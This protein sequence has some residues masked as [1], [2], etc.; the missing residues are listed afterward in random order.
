MS[1]MFKK[2][3]GLAFKPK[4]PTSRSRTAAPTNQPSSQEPHGPVVHDRTQSPLRAIR[5]VTPASGGSPHR[6][7]SAQPTPGDREPDAHVEDRSHQSTTQIARHLIECETEETASTTIPSAG[8]AVVND[9]SEQNDPVISASSLVEARANDEA[10]LQQTRNDNQGPPPE[11]L[12]ALSINKELMLKGQPSNGVITTTVRNGLPS[13][14]LSQEPEIGLGKSPSASDAVNST[15]SAEVER[16]AITQNHVPSLVL[17]GKKTQKDDKPKKATRSNPKKR[18]I[19][20][21]DG[22]EEQLRQQ[23]RR[24]LT[25]DDSETRLVD[26]QKLKM[27]DLTK[28]LHIGK[29]FSR[30]DELRQRERKRRLKAKLAKEE[31]AVAEDA[32]TSENQGIAAPGNQREGPASATLA[33]APAPAATAALPSGPQFRIVDGQIVVDQNSLVMDRHARAMAAQAGQD[34]ETVEEND[35]TRLTTSNSYMNPSKLKGP[36]NWNDAETEQFYLGLKMFGTDFQM[37]S[38]MIKGKQR[39]HVKLKFN[40]EERRDPA[41]IS[42]AVVGEKTTKI[43]LEEYKALTGTEFETVEKIE[44]EQRKRQEDFDA[45]QQRIIDEQ[46]EINRQK[47]EKLFAEK[48]SEQDRDSTKKRG[49]KRKEKVAYGLNGEP[50]TTQS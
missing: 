16:E 2:K 7:T 28:D 29:K 5:T 25:P 22:D 9:S 13:V 39:R 1:S 23:R 4:I 41:R 38:G 10:V 24:S 40:R 44:A 46:V 34:M 11:I 36:N 42:D 47:R 17:S 33:P 12:E 32:E 8:A 50:I 31:A 15:A 26:H 48:E 30:H 19:V 6:A 21:H 3:G 27:S 43:D 20:S 37:I 49:K 45:Q 14:T 18:K 35:F